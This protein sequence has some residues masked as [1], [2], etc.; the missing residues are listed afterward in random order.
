MP[1]LDRPARPAPGYPVPALGDVA[2]FLS[3][4]HCG[5]S[6]SLEAGVLRCGAGHTFDVARQGYVSLLGG[7][8]PAEP[9]DTAAMVAAR[10]AFLDGGHFGPIAEAVADTAE[11]IAAGAAGRC[12]VDV[13]SG[14]GYWLAHVLNRLPAH[15]GLAIDIS[16]PALRRAAR[17]HPRIGAVACDV[18]ALIPVR[19]ACAALVLSVF[20]PRNA[21]EMRRVLGAGGAL[22][23]V[24]PAP[25]HLRELVGAL[26]LLTVDPRKQERLEEALGSGFT[27]VAREPLAFPLALARSASAA[28]AAMGPS[29]WHADPA[30][31]RPAI[32]RLPDPLP[33]TVSVE[34]ATWRPR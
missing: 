34:I 21:P 19:S 33:V 32:D 11:R 9:P 4:P 27:R 23:V 18:R 24:T 31:L 29:A 12:V 26:G 14:P 16:K 2:R 3:C 7:R 8:A 20:A 13:G 15:A 25:D 22:V 5:G 30:A 1:R 6:L 28:A 17:A 10:A